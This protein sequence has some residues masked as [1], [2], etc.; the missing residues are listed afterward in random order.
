MKNGIL[1]SLCF[2][3]YCSFAQNVGI[4]T[5]SPQATLD[6]RGNMRTGGLSKFISFDSVSGKISWNNANLFVPTAQYLMQHS[7]SAEGLY[8]GNN[9]LLYRGI[10]DT[11]FYTDWQNGGG[12]FKGSLGIGTTLPGAK[13]HVVS[14]LSGYTGGNFPGITLEGNG[15]T[16][17][18]IITPNGNESSVLF[19]RAA[20]AAHGGI[21]YNNTGTP[22]GLQFRT[23]GNINRMV[24][25]GTGNVGI[26]NL[27]PVEKLE[28]S[29]NVKANAFNYATPKVCYYT[30]SGVDFNPEVSTDT[31]VKS[32]GLGEVHLN[33]NVAGKGLLAP[34]HLPHGAV[35]QSLT[36]Y[37]TDFSPANLT[38]LVMRKSMTGNVFADNL[39]NITS[40][41]SA[42][43]GSYTSPISFIAANVDNVSYVYYVAAR[44]Y[45]TLPWV[46]LY[47]RS[48]VIQY[49]LSTTQ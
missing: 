31:A 23:A 2:S 41:G 38:V 33:T 9:K 13:L 21:V 24:V 39:G 29:G 8:Y 30:L 7:A 32:M 37:L 43:E 25:S 18:N 27:A 4:G 40:S 10:T 26:G 16:Y 42:G 45:G 5:A 6:V 17:L 35:L 44:V 36:V 47:L 46:A 12:Y 1:L 11:A 48:V 34:L 20:D 3:S 14:G 49:T 15:N 22:N 28:V 19:G